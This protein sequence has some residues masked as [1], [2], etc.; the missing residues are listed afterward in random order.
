MAIYFI[1]VIYRKSRVR[2]TIIIIIITIIIY[3]IMISAIIF[4]TTKLL[5]ASLHSDIYLL[6]TR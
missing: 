6:N 3:V 5:I 1:I 2:H 4:N